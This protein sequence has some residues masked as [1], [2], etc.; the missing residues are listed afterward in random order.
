[1]MQELSEPG[2][3]EKQIGVRIG[4]GDGSIP[5]G[6]LGKRWLISSFTGDQ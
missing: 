6:R 5:V 2:A 4:G 1:M 3:V